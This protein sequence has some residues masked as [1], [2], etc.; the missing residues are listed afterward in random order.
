VIK[1]LGIFL[2]LLLLQLQAFGQAKDTLTV[3]FTGMGEGEIYKMCNGHTLLSV[4]KTKSKQGF[5][6][7]FKI[8]LSPKLKDGTGMDITVL[9]KGRFGIWFRDTNL[10]VAYSSQ[11]RYLVVSKNLNL[12]RRRSVEYKWSDDE[13]IKPSRVD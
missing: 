1:L 5:K 8:S 3:F 12:K 2:V 13:P 11:R 6:K 9:R 4:V 7:V 10:L